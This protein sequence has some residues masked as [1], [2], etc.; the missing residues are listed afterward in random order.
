MAE[1]RERGTP[2]EGHPKLWIGL[3]CQSG[4]SPALICHAV[5]SVMRSHHLSMSAIAGAATLD[6]KTH[7]VGLVAFC[8]AHDIRLYG[9]SADQLATVQVPHPSAAVHSA[10]KT[11]SVAEAAAL[12]AA[13]GAIRGGDRPTLVV[14]KQVVQL[15]GEPGRVTIAVTQEN[16]KTP[17]PVTEFSAYAPLD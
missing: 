16:A 11:P 2:G 9:F 4:S 3:G 14:P 10:V 1:A 12:L 6:R 13:Q 5:E 8:A 15:V 17:L 7:E